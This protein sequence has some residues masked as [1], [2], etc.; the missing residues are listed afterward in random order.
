LLLRPG[1]AS[2]GSRLFAAL[3][4]TF[5][6]GLLLR[7]GLA[8]FGSGLFA[9]LCLALGTGLLLRSGLAGFGP[10]LFAALCLALGTGLLLRTR[11]A[12]VGSRLFSSFRRISGFAGAFR[13]FG[14]RGLRLLRGLAATRFALCRLTGFSLSGFRGLALGLRSRFR[15]RSLL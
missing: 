10:G 3:G 13:R 5:G 7:P 6:T 9:A 14:G 4:L 12:S 15:F 2:F 1:L 8:G 11:L